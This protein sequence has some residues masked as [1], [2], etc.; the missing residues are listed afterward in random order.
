MGKSLPSN[1][2]KDL[3]RIL[4]S[5]SSEKRVHRS[6]TKH[7]KPPPPPPAVK[8]RPETLTTRRTA[9]GK[10][11]GRIELEPVKKSRMEGILE[12]QERLP[13]SLVVSDCV[14][15]WFHDTLK[16]AKNG[17]VSMQVLVG[18]MYFSGYGVARDPQ[19]VQSFIFFSCFCVW[20]FFF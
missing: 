4:S 20:G 1:K 12:G 17:D 6:K 8:P 5:S 15:R 19:K 14:K 2:L 7:L 16:E 11:G 10:Q 3:A 18:Q 9:T 13:L